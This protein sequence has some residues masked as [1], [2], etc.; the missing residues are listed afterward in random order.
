GQRVVVVSA[1]NLGERWISLAEAYDC[2]VTALRYEWG[3]TP[4][5]DDLAAKLDEAGGARAVFLTHSETSTGV[6][7]D[8]QAL[9]AAARACD[10]LRLGRRLGAAGAVGV[11][12]LLLRLGAHAQGTGEGRLGLHAGRLARRRAER[13]ARAPARAGPRRRLRA[14][15]PARPRVP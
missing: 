14:A 2:D 4:S 6:V 3:E 5:A 9:A 10:G 8:V 13:R 7:A 11:A 15:S 12:A 1:G